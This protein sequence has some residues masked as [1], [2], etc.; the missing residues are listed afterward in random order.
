MFAPNKNKVDMSNLIN[1]DNKPSKLSLKEFERQEKKRNLILQKNKKIIDES[2]RNIQ[3][4]I[5]SAKIDLD[6]SQLEPIIL[7][8]EQMI[9]WEQKSLVSRTISSYAKYHQGKI[10]GKQL[11]IKLLKTIIKNNKNKNNQNYG[12]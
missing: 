3:L 10:E 1:D 5:D 9:E 12:R 6:P 2:D 8:L 4:I 7:W 11:A